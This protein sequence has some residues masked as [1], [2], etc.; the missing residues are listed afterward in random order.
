MTRFELKAIS[1]GAIEKAIEKAER[2]RLLND[3]EQAESIC[4]DV[5]RVEAQHQAALRILILA[6]TDQFAHGHGHGGG[7]EARDHVARLHDAYERTYY[8]GLVAERE[9][10]ALL[11]RHGVGSAAY[12]GFRQAMDHYEEA[13]AIRPAGND[14][15]LLRWNS[16]VRSIERHRLEAE[17][18]SGELPLE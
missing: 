14:D 3:P 16:C 5:L 11:E 9:A 17:A 10:R 13:E 2:Y 18:D 6:L 15:A 12:H 1:A 7:R 4:R 8:L